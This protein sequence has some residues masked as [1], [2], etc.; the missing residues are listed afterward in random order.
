MG[1]PE[2]IDK[3]S[4]IIMGCIFR[5]LRAKD[6]CNGKKKKEKE[7]KKEERRKK[8]Q[9]FVYYFSRIDNEPWPFLYICMILI[10]FTLLLVLYVTE[11]CMYVHT[12]HIEVLRTYLS[13]R[14]VVYQ[15][16][17]LISPWVYINLFGFSFWFFFLVYFL[18]FI[19]FFLVFSC[20]IITYD[21]QTIELKLIKF[22][23]FIL[24]I[25]QALFFL[26]IEKVDYYYYYFFI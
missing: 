19:F 13:L 2:I 26:R 18:F 5:L 21:L 14:V 25:I 8:L 11:Y 22:I 17:F 4:P 24:V 6:F 16:K 23:Y 1:Y 10:Y 20:F 9:S 12:Y 7:I 3:S 15:S